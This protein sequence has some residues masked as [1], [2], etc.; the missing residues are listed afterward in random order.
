MTRIRPADIVIKSADA[1]SGSDGIH[2]PTQRFV[3]TFGLETGPAGLRFRQLAEH[4]HEIGEYLTLPTK[5]GAGLVSD[6]QVLDIIHA[7][8]AFPVAFGPQVIRHCA[9]DGR[10]PRP[11]APAALR[12][13]TSSSTAACSTTFR[14]G[15]RSA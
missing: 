4:D 5:D 12:W 1:Q 15:W 10:R 2:I 8:S 13:P 3:S 6:D 7:S 14:S 11:A 9:E